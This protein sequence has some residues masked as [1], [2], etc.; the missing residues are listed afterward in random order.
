VEGRY[1]QEFD[2]IDLLLRPRAVEVDEPFWQ[3]SPLL[4]TMQL[5]LHAQSTGPLYVRS[6]NLAD[7]SLSASLDIANTLSDPRID[8][9]IHVDDGG[10]LTLPFVRI[11]FVTNSGQITFDGDLRIPDQT[12][13]L[14]ISATGISIDRF[15]NSHNIL[16]K[17]TGT[18][19]APVLEWSSPDFPDK[20]QLLALLLSGRTLDQL[21][22]GALSIDSTAS[23]SS[24][25]A[26]MNSDGIAK[27]TTGQ[28]LNNLISDP[29]R[30][31]VGLDTMSIEFGTGSVDLKGCKRF[32]RLV[33]TCAQGELGFVGASHYEGRAELRLSDY[34]SGLIR[35]E[36]LSQGIDTADASGA[37][38]KLE[39][40]LKYPLRF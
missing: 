37:R 16:L 30:K 36:Y 7:F 25:R 22:A 10:S 6:K 4:E 12:P 5:R 24:V 8:G 29:V 40:N 21:R 13:S 20:S 35:L 32:G 34:F 19:R 27:S 38:G 26:A 11:P 39:L 33:R 17:L 2:F 14:D 31:V 18:L 15:E 1:T 23:G 3:G 28:L 9:T